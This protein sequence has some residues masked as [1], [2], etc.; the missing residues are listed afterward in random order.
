MRTYGLARLTKDIEKVTDNLYKLSLAEN[1]YNSQTEEQD[2]HFWNAIAFGKK[3][4]ALFNSVHKGDRINITNS[5]MK[6]NNYEVA[7]EKK[8]GTQMVIFDF[9]FIEKKDSYGTG[10]NLPRQEKVN[11]QQDDFTPKRSTQSIDVSEDDLPF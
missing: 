6:N 2:G 7:G 8:Y 4:E 1:I 10:A 11:R 5:I 3:G 9:D